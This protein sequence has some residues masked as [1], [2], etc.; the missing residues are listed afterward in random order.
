MVAS[1]IYS[2]DGQNRY[3]TPE[4]SGA[5][6]PTQTKTVDPESFVCGLLR[7]A[8]RDRSADARSLLTHPRGR[9]GAETEHAC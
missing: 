3:S 7:G 6:Y 5:V 8:V 1:L 4:I 9:G 2:R